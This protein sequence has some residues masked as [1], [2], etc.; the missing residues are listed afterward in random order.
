MLKTLS[1]YLL[2]IL[3]ICLTYNGAYSLEYSNQ[4]T[5]V[6]QGNLLQSA[7]I[8]KYV[9]F[10]VDQ[11]DTATIYNLQNVTS[12]FEKN[13][14]DVINLATQT[15]STWFKLLLRNETFDGHFQ[16]EIDNPMLNDA[17]FFFKN[18]E[19]TWSSQLISKDF[20]FE[21][22]AVHSQK[23]I[24][25]VTM[26]QGDLQTFF[27]RVKSNSQIVLPFKI[28][29]SEQISSR[30]NSEDI[31]SSL[32]FGIMLVMFL[33]N[34]FIFFTVRDKSYLYYIIY[35]F[36]VALV[37]L[38]IKGLGF[39]FLWP[40][41]PQFEQ[42]SLFLFPSLTAF[43][44]I[45]FIRSFLHTKQYTPILHKGFS[46]FIAAYIITLGVA[47]FGDK[48]VSYN[49]L[50]INALPLALYMIGIALYIRIKHNYRPAIFFL[51]AWTFFLVGIILFVLKEAGVFPFNIYTNSFILIGSS[52][53]AV[54]L[55]FALADKINIYRDE[56]EK[57]QQTALLAAQENEQIIREQN[58]TLEI[59]VTER[60][61]ELKIA[62]EEIN[63]TLYDLKETQSQ[64]VESEKMAS[65]GQLT[66]GIAHEI[67]NP[68]NF[69]T[70]NV[71]P[72]KRDVD[73]LL[74]LIIQLEQIAKTGLDPTQM[75]AKI[76]SL[77][78]EFDFDY[79]QEEIS[80]LLK[81]I[82][83][84]SSR[85]AE[86]VKGLRIFSRVDEDD[87]KKAD[88]NEGLDSTI[89][90]INNLLNGKI[91][92]Q[93]D[94]GNIPLIECYPGKLNQVFLNLISNAIYAINSKLDGA[95]GG[96]ITITTSF[97]ENT[98]R[99]S[100]AD[101][102]VGMN[103]ATLKKLFE[104]FFTTKPVG[105]GTGLGLSISFNTIKKHNGSIKVNSV[106]DV[107]T[108]FIIEIPIIQTIN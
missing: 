12:L 38:N 29:T 81:G 21:N 101:N 91:T 66:A 107:G 30:N 19:G 98:V 65:L 102:G 59:K 85:T 48:T 67:N 90:I 4:D 24:F 106:L 13:T 36:C 53:E 9:T 33:Y 7:Q 68:I 52:I 103:E 42:L 99:I 56:K 47:W 8:G 79:L 89:I 100:I 22:R 80:F 45:A 77:K 49:L 93:R 1:R 61:S 83:E 2:I 105:E 27:I 34:M 37:Q 71:K 16:I 58:V 60:T 72:L 23:L 76:N 35:I 73:I 86:I 104:P 70:S 84:G 51:I 32:Y 28:G 18:K 40:S 62:N 46:I 25:P 5:I 14:S 44:S 55:S 43:S 63:K 108:D 50:N 41:F 57:A 87:L 3:A 11:Q 69:V 88:V 26:Q 96:L 95:S 94:Y 78:A 74:D 15:K 92:I 31:V 64:L 82:N 39:K 97:H 20:A 54:L 17:E 75:E 10:Y 6:Y